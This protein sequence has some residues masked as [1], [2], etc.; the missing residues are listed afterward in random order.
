MNVKNYFLLFIPTPKFL[1]WGFAFCLLLSYSYAQDAAEQNDII[2]QTIETIAEDAEDEGIDYTTLF[3]ELTT[4]YQS[5]LNLNTASQEQ[6]EGLL[7]LNKFQ[8][9]N[10]L[11]H[12]ENNGKLMTIYELQ[13]IEGFDLDA[14]SNILPFV[15]VTKDIDAPHLSAKEILKEG[16]HEVFIRYQ[17]ILE[18]Q[19]GYTPPDTNSDGT[20]TSRYAGS[21]DKIYTRYRFK[22]SNKIS[23]GFTTEKD[24]GEELFKGSKP[25]GFDYYSAHFYLRNIGKIK[26]LAIGDYHAQFGQGL[27]FWSGYS[28]TRRDAANVM[29]IKMNA[30]SIR[31]YASVDENLFMRGMAATLGFN[32]FEITAFF[33]AKKIDGNISVQDTISEEVQEISSFQ[34]TGFHRTA[35]ELF[36]QDA[37]DEKIYGA[38]LAYK[39]RKMSVGVTAV[40]SS[41]SA[42]LQ[43]DLK[44]YNQFEFSDEN[45]VNIGADYNFIFE[46][47]NFF[48]EVSRSKNGG[49]AYLNGMLV[50]LD[51]RLSLS[52]LQR[53]YQRNYQA[54][55]SNAIGESS[56]NANE[57]GFYIGV[58]AVPI[59]KWTISAYYDVFTFPW[60]KFLADAPSH[61]NEFDMQITYKPS[62]K[63][64]M[65]IK[66]QHEI[67]QQNTSEDIKTI[68]FLVN[69]DRQ[70]LRYNMSYKVSESVKLR[71]RIQLS[72]Y[73]L[74][75][76]LIF[77]DVIYRKNQSPFSFTFRYSLFDTDSWDSRIYVYEHD[78]LYAYSI[79]AFHKRGMRT[80]LILRYK[81]AHGID[82]WLRYSQ[83]YYNN[84]DVISSSLNEIQGSAKSE[85]KAQVRLKF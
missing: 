2:E 4:L 61:G 5:P 38:N 39:K 60:L 36:D 12:I 29:N 72:R 85:V 22:Y 15:K 31:P 9:N 53:N 43:R 45:N 57:K 79:P 1:A 27:T 50:S 75:G 74:G 6:L 73:Q 46:N 71:N 69:R 40:S 37:I 54:L 13:T 41:Y 26:H 16:K 83:T 70:K 25:N 28:F 32:K 10:L 20:L 78:V 56:K 18:E 19:K 77:Q 35:N 11:E 30:R 51:P 76:Y 8:I 82:I 65:Y 23:W 52:V 59:K 55:F 66:Y 24:A 48:G 67:K 34:T 3:D 63:L 64:E 14:I 17:R 21:P 68:D 62:K 84:L 42:N 81:I 7:L 44:I 49:F 33:S 80:Y 47:F 58:V